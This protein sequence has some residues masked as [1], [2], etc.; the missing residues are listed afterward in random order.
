M[1]MD[2][3]KEACF[4]R[5]SRTLVSCPRPS[6]ITSPGRKTA[7]LA[8]DRSYPR[9][10]FDGS[11]WTELCIL[12]GLRVW[13]H[14]LMRNWNCL[15]PIV[16]TSVSVVRVFE[17]IFLKTYF[18][19]ISYYLKLNMWTSIHY[20]T[21]AKC[22]VLNRH[23]SYYMYSQQIFQI[24]N[25]T[26]VFKTN[27]RDFETLTCRYH[28]YDVWD[29]LHREPVPSHNLALQ[30]PELCPWHRTLDE[31]VRVLGQGC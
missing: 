1:T 31:S 11:Y 6:V 22:D 4:P 17:K 23:Y 5:S 18:M 13:T 30:Y 20:E 26:F 25:W 19:G 3:G 8:G 10:Y 15:W 7:R 14:C 12:S 16:N 24:V 9:S 28:C 27:F 29:Q 21:I 2:C